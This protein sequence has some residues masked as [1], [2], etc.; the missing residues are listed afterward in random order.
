MKKQ[1]IFVMMCSLLML[2]SCATYTGQGAYM[3]A[4]IGG[5]LGSAFGGYSGGWR[6]QQAGQLVG[7]A[8]GA[9][10][11]AAVGAAED[12]RQAERIEQ[13]SA[14]RARKAA[15]RRAS[16]A[17]RSEEGLDGVYENGVVRPAKTSADDSGFDPT[18]S[19]DDR[20]DFGIKR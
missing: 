15:A 7:M 18:N 9:A 3:G 14:A 5:L 6:G 4:S 13:Y 11:G 16:S 10:V 2:S 19:G 17:A 12:K 8:T 1:M 20:V